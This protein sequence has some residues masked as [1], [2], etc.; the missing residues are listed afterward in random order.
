MKAK[1]T[2]TLMSVLHEIDENNAIIHDKQDSD[3]KL[4]ENL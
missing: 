3:G 4:T 1:R 2:W